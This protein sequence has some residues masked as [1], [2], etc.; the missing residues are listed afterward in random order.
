VAAD[1]DDAA[2][3]ERGFQGA[4]GAFCL[5]SFWEHLSAEREIAQAGIMAQ[6]A[7]KAGVAHTI[8]ST[9]EDTRQSVPLSDRRMP[10]L[11]G[12]YKVAHFDGKGEADGLFRA[13]GAP[14]TYLLTSFHWD[15]FINFGVGPKPGP[16]GKLAIAF[17][18]G[19]RPLP[20]IAAEDVGKCA[21]GVFKR[22]PEFLGK[23]IGIAGEHLTGAQI[24]SAMSRALG[25]E[26]VYNAVPPATYRNFGFPS[27][28]DVGN[29]FQYFH[30][31][32]D[33]FR[34]RRDVAFSRSLNPELMSFEQWL[35]KHGNRIP[36]G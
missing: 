10:T 7:K 33:A 35:R 6:A 3:V 14:V 28:P 31:F 25:I 4:H 1:L 2:T 12:K 27:A 24:A 15:N 23:T 13:S 5:T 34:A 36:L 17:P 22:G 11:R 18:M 8:W 29:M 19:E 26:I 16:D 21:Y 9:L 30:D 20:G 32:N